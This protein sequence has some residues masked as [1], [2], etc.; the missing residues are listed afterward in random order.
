MKN[1][2]FQGS[3]G[4]L[5]ERLIQQALER[6]TRRVEGPARTQSA[7]TAP[8]EFPGDATLARPA[9]TLRAIASISAA[10][11][12]QQL[13]V[14]RKRCQAGHRKPVFSLHTKAWLGVG[15][16]LQIATAAKLSN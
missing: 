14:V 7:S 5:K 11:G 16:A 6:R 1:K 15:L 12:Y 9:A 8:E 13:R 2:G 10:S 3:R 4:R